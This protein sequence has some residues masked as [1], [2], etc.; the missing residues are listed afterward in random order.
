MTARSVPA[1]GDEPS[2][3]LA[4][5]VC[6][7]LI[8]I[9]PQ[10]GW[11][12]VKELAPTSELGRIWSLSRPLTYRAVDTLE[13]KGMIVRGEPEVTKG[14]A[15]VSLRSTPLG[16]R[17]VQLWLNT[18]VDHVR[19]L[20]TTFLLKATLLRRAGGDVTA[21]LQ[22]QERTLLPVIESLTTKPPD[23]T[24]LAD[25]WRRQ[26]ASAAQRFFDDMR[27]GLPAS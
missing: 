15:R 6:L 9:Q 20:R 3:S 4:E 5:E 7:T 27:R 23:Y 25:L 16:R 12:I 10:H 13:L 18:P 19:D 2:L 21:L 24:D 26:A 17:R 11:S 1:S 14:P 8:S 22:A